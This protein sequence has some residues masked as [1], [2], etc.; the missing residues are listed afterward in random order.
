MAK[1]SEWLDGNGFP[2]DDKKIKK[3]VICGEEIHKGGFWHGDEVIACCQ[4]DANKLIDLYLDTMADVGTFKGMSKEKQI[5]YVSKLVAEKI[6]NKIEIDDRN[7]KRKV[8]EKFGF[9]YFAELG[10][11]DYWGM[12][13]TKDELQEKIVGDIYFPG[14]TEKITKEDVEICHNSIIEIIAKETG[15]EPVKIGYFAFPE[16]TYNTFK[17]GC[18]AKIE[19]NG[20]SFVFLDDSDLINVFSINEFSPT[21]KKCII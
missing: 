12:T 11:M 19:N 4:Y 17:I 9:T 20:S 16:F 15:E 21:I 7:N 8:M 1:I 13:L 5:E 14:M 10:Q 6:T 2:E 18:V 3:C